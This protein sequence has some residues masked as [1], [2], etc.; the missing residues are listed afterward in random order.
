M[1]NQPK[2]FLKLDISDLLMNIE[3]QQ[4][5]AFTCSLFI[6][7]EKTEVSLIFFFFYFRFHSQDSMLSSK[8]HA[9]SWAPEAGA[10]CTL[11]S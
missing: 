10:A 3:I 1:N 5:A 9:S 7:L 2:C 6:H 8:P 11:K 4:S